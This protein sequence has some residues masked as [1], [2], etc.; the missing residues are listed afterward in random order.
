LALGFLLRVFLIAQIQHEALFPCLKF[1]Y[2]WLRSGF[3]TA[4]KLLEYLESALMQVDVNDPNRQGVGVSGMNGKG[5][6]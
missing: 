4:F 1:L 5:E 6:R 3:S 2:E